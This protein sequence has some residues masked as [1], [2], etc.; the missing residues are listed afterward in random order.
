VARLL[1]F[2]QAREIAGRS[3]AELPGATV[4]EVLGAAVA[5]YGPELAALLE[6]SRVWVNGDE[7]IDGPATVVNATDE[8]A[9]IPPVSGG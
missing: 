9:I 5:A 1:L 2:A 7:P 4:A 6:C 3:S 8:V